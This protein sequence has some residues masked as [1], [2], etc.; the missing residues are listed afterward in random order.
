MKHT[1]FSHHISTYNKLT[2]K[3]LSL[4]SIVLLL[5]ILIVLFFITRGGAP[6]SSELGYIE[7]STLGKNAG[8]VVPASCDSATPW[9]S[10]TLAGGTA[11]SHFY[12]DCTTPCPSGVGTYDPYFDPSHA[13]CPAA[14][15]CA[16]YNGSIVAGACTFNVNVG[17]TASGGNYISSSVAAPAGYTGNLT[18]NCSNGV[19]SSGASTCTAPA[20]LPSATCGGSV[21][22][23]ATGSAGTVYYQCF[24]QNAFDDTGNGYGPCGTAYWGTQM[25]DQLPEWDWQCSGA[26]L[27]TQ[28]CGILDTTPPSVNIYFY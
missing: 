21:G 23:C 6:Y 3:H 17:I 14:A 20:A 18:R 2:R 15:S 7:H 5:T 11:G 10:P 4:L 9:T 27:T 24:N 12:G 13:A 26:G 22:T 25:Y 28:W 1:Y 16:A 8:S 19:W